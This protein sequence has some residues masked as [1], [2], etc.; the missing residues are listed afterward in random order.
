MHRVSPTSAIGLWTPR[1]DSEPNQTNGTTAS[2]HEPKAGGVF[3]DGCEFLSLGPFN[4]SL[5]WLL[6]CSQGQFEA[7]RS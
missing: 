4:N 3:G 6:L 2:E 5:E 1:L 7:Q